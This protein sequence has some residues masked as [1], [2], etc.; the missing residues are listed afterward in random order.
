MIDQL[1]KATQDAE[2]QKYSLQRELHKYQKEPYSFK[3]AIYEDRKKRTKDSRL[4]ENKN[5]L[6]LERRIQE[7]DDRKV[8]RAKQLKKKNEA[9]KAKQAEPA[10]ENLIH[11]IK[12]ANSSM[13]ADVCLSKDYQKL[14][15]PTKS[16]FESIN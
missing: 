1:T 16:R 3:E 6:S 5:E 14:A 8:F 9:M 13:E 4:I 7:G 12:I 10:E 15:A 11:K 2:K